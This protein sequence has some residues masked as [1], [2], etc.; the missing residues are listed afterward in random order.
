VYEIVVSDS[1][2]CS[3]DITSVEIFDS[4][5]YGCSDPLAC[6][7]NPLATCD[8]E[9]C[10]YI[11]ESDLNDD[12]NVD[13]TDLIL[14]LSNFGCVLGCEPY[15]INDDGIISVDDIIELVGDL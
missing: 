7:F 13:V 9:N 2:N 8:S 12:C 4:T 15:D 5:V 10:I 11:L 14:M 1:S 6:N 3:P